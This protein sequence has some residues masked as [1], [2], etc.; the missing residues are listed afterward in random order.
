MRKCL[1]RLISI[2]L[3]V[4]LCAGVLISVTAAETSVDISSRE[5]ALLKQI[6]VITT[7]SMTKDELSAPVTRANFV[8]YAAKLLNLPDNL[9]LENEYFIDLDKSPKKMI[10]NYFVQMGL[11]SVN[12]DR[13]FEPDRAILKTEA[14]KI[15]VDILGYKPLVQEKGGYTLGY[16]QIANRIGINCSD[17]SGELSCAEAYNLLAEALEIPIYD[18]KVFAEDYVEYETSE[19]VTLLTEYHS[20]YSAIGYLRSV[21][22]I[23]LDSKPVNKDQIL[24]GNEIFSFDDEMLITLEE[25]LGLYVEVFYFSN[26]GISDKTVA[27]VEKEENKNIEEISIKNINGLTDNYE[28]EYF[29]VGTNKTKSFHIDRGARV[30]YN[31]KLETYDTKNLLNSL[32]NGYVRLLDINNDGGYEYCVV[33]DYTDFVVGYIDAETMTV[34]NKLDYSSI[35]LSEC[36]Q[37]IV[38]DVLNSGVSFDFIAENNVLSVAK[39][40]D[41]SVIDIILCSNSVNGTVEFV[42]NAGEYTVAKINGAEYEI[43]DTALHRTAIKPGIVG[44]FYLNSYGQISYVLLKVS[45]DYRYVFA[46]QGMYV[47]QGIDGNMK[48]KVMETNGAKKILEASD[49][50]RVDGIKYAPKQ[51]LSAIPE[52]TNE[53]LYPQVLKIRTND[54][55]FI[56]HIDTK[57]YNADGGESLENSLMATEPK[58]TPYVESCGTSGKYKRIGENVVISTSSVVFSVPLISNLLQGDFEEK[59]LRVVPF[60]DLKTDSRLESSVLYKSDINQT[61]ED[62]LLCFDYKANLKYPHNNIFVVSEITNELTSDGDAKGKLYGYVNGNPVFYWIDDEYL[63]TIKAMQIDEGDA[64]VY[65]FNESKEINDIIMIYDAS[66]GGEPYSQSNSL[67]V[68]KNRFID[69]LSYFSKDFSCTFMYAGFKETDIVKGFYDLGSDYMTYCDD[70]IY[71][72]TATVVDLAEK[73]GNRVSSG[74]I[75][76]IRAAREVGEENC[77]MLLV[78][79]R[80][81]TQNSV[82]IYNR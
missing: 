58:G 51:V 19:S 2:V 54:E 41:G 65:S 64:I 55:G 43:A 62:V 5:I 77:S 29:T 48:M 76:D 56:T 46:Y 72:N 13:M 27:F 23:S 49:A 12:N 20:I 18:P 39:S 24:V 78:Q 33:K 59:Q 63:S 6:G 25:M 15:L 40:I 74:T 71:C 21:G 22:A 1:R 82:V 52:S 7:S 80:W 45:D 38:K 81:F 30:I 67:W 28:L 10:I 47:E 53:K 9:S 3:C 75:N 79:Y 42:K 60:N 37:Y 69:N 16:L 35:T 61:V 50:V 32:T 44:N 34:F 68:T 73:E 11:L 8:S 4:S 36:E 26:D 17:T 57:K 66:Q 70:V 14:I 31:G